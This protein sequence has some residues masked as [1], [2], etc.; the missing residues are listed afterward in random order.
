MQAVSDTTTVPEPVPEKITDLQVK[1]TKYAT[2]LDPRG[3]I[4][5]YEFTINSQP[6]LWDRE[7]GYVYWT[8]I[9]KALGREK[10]EIAKI[11]DA[12]PTMANVIKKIRG[13]FLKIQGTWVPFENA[14]TLAIRTCYP[15]RNE[16]TVMFGPS[17][18]NEALEPSHPRY[19]RA[20]ASHE[21][22]D[23]T[24]KPVA[25]KRK[26]SP[27]SAALSLLRSARLGHHAHWAD[28]Q[29]MPPLSSLLTYGKP[30]PSSSWSEKNTLPPL[31]TSHSTSGSNWNTKTVYSSPP[32]H[33][34]TE[35][36]CS[37]DFRADPTQLNEAISASLC[38]LQLSR[39]TD[40]TVQP[41]SSFSIAG[42]NFQWM[43]HTYRPVD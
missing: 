25:P 42:S 29:R 19:L 30:N 34:S 5:V 10:S 22:R 3:F 4:P 41:P 39:G 38:L 6:I 16:L 43:G 35:S 17:F 26:R 13:G 27:T 12:D 21:N 8:G 18:A 2:S 32:S 1:M 7:S 14:K 37:E 31:K 9:W 15:I 40:P 28:P 11:V 36:F 24:R 20:P 33:S 23:G